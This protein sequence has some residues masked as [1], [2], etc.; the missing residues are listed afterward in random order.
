MCGQTKD[1]N[2]K[3]SI[4]NKKKIISD[5]FAK[6]THATCAISAS[7]P[8][9]AATRHIDDRIID[10]AYCYKLHTIVVLRRKQ[11]LQVA[12]INIKFLIPLI[13]TDRRIFFFFLLVALANNC[14][15]RRDVHMPHTHEHVMRIL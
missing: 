5:K 6:C 3:H 12:C 8:P 2:S 11:K 15:S 9:P 1:R 13:G 4:E 10:R 7:R 14:G